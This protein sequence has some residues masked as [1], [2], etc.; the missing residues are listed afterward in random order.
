MSRKFTAVLLVIAVALFFSIVYFSWIPSPRLTEVSWLPSWVSKWADEN[1]RLRTAV[2]FV[3]LGL[4]IGVAFIHQ[5]QLWR[6]GWWQWWIILT[7]LAAGVELGQLALPRRVFDLIDIF[8]GSAGGG[9]GILAAFLAQFFLTRVM[10]R[11]LGCNLPQQQPAIDLMMN[12]MALPLDSVSSSMSPPLYFLGL[13]FWNDETDKLLREMDRNGGMLAV[14]SA[15]SLA[16]AA[17]DP[18]LMKAYQT[19]DWSVV[20]G[21]YVA[22][23]LRMFG[24]SVRR[25]SGLQLIEK[26]TASAAVSPIP[27]RERKVLWVIPSL[28]EGERIRKF[29][30]KVDFEKD[31]Q[32]FYLAPFYKSDEEFDDRQLIAAVRE[33]DPDWIILCLGGGR[34]EKLGYYLREATLM[35]NQRPVILCTGAA[36]AFFTG[37]QAKI[38]KWVDRMYL[39]WLMR[40]ME[41]P[42]DFVPRY[43]KAAWHFPVSLWRVRGTWFDTPEGG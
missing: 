12:S 7:G 2:P 13:R 15:P 43:V 27:L 23:I 40:M 35:A 34:Q 8:W 4:V 41:K 28:A 6:K 37:G 9:F 26:M 3:G 25:I 11:K 5:Q 1:E 38:P 32:H 33:M 19:S 21:G 29:L 30:G 18:L 20:D 42:Q 14:P 10:G 17:E 36:I 24:K 16:Q 31:R 22:L 39:G